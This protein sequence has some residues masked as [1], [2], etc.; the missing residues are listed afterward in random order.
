M[1]ANTARAPL[2]VR[3]RQI[4]APV[5]AQPDHQPQFEAQVQQAVAEAIHNP[6]PAY[7]TYDGD[8]G[9]TVEPYIPSGMQAH[10]E[11]PIRTPEPPIPS[12][13]VP[14]HAERPEG[15]RR[16]PR[17]EELPAV[18]RRSLVA[19]ERHD[20]EPRNARALFKRLASNVGIGLRPQAAPPANPVRDSAA[21][22]AAAR[23]AIEA[24]GP[25]I[26]GNSAASEGAA[27]RL[28]ANGRP[29]P[30]KEHIEIPSFLRK[31]G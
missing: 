27:G 14:S 12:V 13:Y 22:D 1:K 30:Q 2:A 25:R 17:T 18:A 16:V 10:I 29:L 24:G 19:E 20:P 21:E 31:H 9:V 23:S 28:D 5:M 3:P 7:S 26:S 6:Q 11:E 15:Q 4:E 8:D